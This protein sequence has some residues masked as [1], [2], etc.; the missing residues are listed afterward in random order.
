MR[1]PGLAGGGVP[2][3][4]FDIGPRSPGL[5]GGAVPPTPCARSCTG[6]STRPM[7]NNAA[8]VLPDHVFDVALG[9]CLGIRFSEL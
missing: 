9:N 4:P 8:V 5:G 2:P 1:W 3:T 6:V 7:A